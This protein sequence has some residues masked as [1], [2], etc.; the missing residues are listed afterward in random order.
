MTAMEMGE[1]T[2]EAFAPEGVSEEEAGSLAFEMSIGGVEVDTYNYGDIVRLFDPE[3]EPGSG[4]EPFETVA[5]TMSAYDWGISAEGVDFSIGDLRIED[6]GARRPTL[7]VLARADEMYIAA[8]E[9]GEEPDPAQVIDLISAF[10]GAFRLGLMEIRD[11]EGSSEDF[12]GALASAGIA[13]LS[14]EGIESIHYRGLE[15]SDA[16]GDME[17]R[18][19]DF[20]ISDFRFPS[21]AALIGFE[22][23][24]EE[25][26]IDTMLAAIPSLGAI[27]VSD[28]FVNVPFMAELS[29]TRAA[30]E[31]SD[32]IGPIPTR[33]RNM[34]ED[35]RMPTWMLDDESF[36]VMDGLGY[37]EIGTS[38]DLQLVWQ[39]TDQT[40]SLVSE[41]VLE[42]GG[43]M[44]LTATLGGIPR[45]ALENPMS[46]MFLAFATTLHEATLE[47]EDN[48]LTERALAMLARDQGT[49]VGT[50]R[51]QALGIIPFLAAP[52]Q[53]PDFLMALTSAASTFLGEPGTVRLTMIPDAPV[54][55]MQLMEASESD[56]PG[57]IIDLLNVQ[58]SAE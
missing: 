13:G 12:S 14:A 43:R 23:A 18:L 35:L 47:F 50:M 16:G 4:D 1:I 54:P 55:I 51:A 37:E 56:D 52:L 25:G 8:T 9:S 44:R 30:I 15:A 20:T 39:E 21:L 27:S 57:L 48:S 19:G 6:L 38:S 7:P 5:G 3:L 53:R 31:M 24:Q 46:L 33:I 11:V 42:D 32:H 29:L 41:N 45:E 34:I 17:V 58:V 26:D 28:L 2:V 49:D 22:A 40:V 10:Y 36:E